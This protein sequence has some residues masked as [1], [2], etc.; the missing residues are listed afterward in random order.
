MAVGDVSGTRS[1][2]KGARAE[3]EVVN[4]L[5]RNGWPHAERRLMGQPDDTGDVIGIGPITLE[6]KNH[7]RLELGTWATQLEAEMNQA[8]N[9]VGAV[10]HKRRGRTDV[11]EWFATM[12]V[13]VLLRLLNEAGYGEDWVPC[14][15]CPETDCA[16]CEET[17][18]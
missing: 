18:A 13:H 1:R 16:M 11:A 15:T 10:I 5:R 4:H 12:P 17:T 3:T 14:H 8:Q 6:I 2:R 9:T 7:A